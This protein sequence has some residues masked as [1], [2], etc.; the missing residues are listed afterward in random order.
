MGMKRGT[1]W[2][3]LVD[4]RAVTQRRLAVRLRRALADHNCPVKVHWH[5]QGRAAFYR[6]YVEPVNLCM[7]Q[8]IY[9]ALRESAL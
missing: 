3:R 2:R 5:G 6:I 1:K 4:L 9:M 8:T 7:A